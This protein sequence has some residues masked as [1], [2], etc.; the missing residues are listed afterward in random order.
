MVLPALR[1]GGYEYQSQVNIGQRPGGR[2]HIVDVLARKEGEE[3]PI[4][5][6]W[7]QTSG[8]AEQK[9][10][11]EIICLA[12]AI[13]HSE[14]RFGRAYVVLGG[15]GWSLREAFLNHL[16]DGYL[17]GCEAVRVVTLEDFIARAN[18]GK[19]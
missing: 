19:L 10:P 3:I 2:R 14:G 7:Q 18:S 4:S 17:C 12:H 1:K 13:D 5:L 8:T 6:K 9:V 16:L 11:Y 15:P